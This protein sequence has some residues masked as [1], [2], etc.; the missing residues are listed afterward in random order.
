MYTLLDDYL[1]PRVTPERK[2]LLVQA[3]IT[4]ESLGH[5]AALDELNSVLMIQDTTDTVT[6]LGRIGTVVDTAQDQILLMQGIILSPELDLKNKHSILSLINNLEYYV[7]PDQAELLFMGD[8]DNESLLVNLVNMMEG[9]DDLDVMLSYVHQVSDQ[10]ISY[11]KDLVYSQLSARAVSNEYIAPVSKIRYINKVF[12]AFG[13]EPF[14]LAVDLIE[15]GTRIGNPLA[16]ILDIRLEQLGYEHEVLVPGLIG[17]VII[18]DVEPELTF[19]AVTDVIETLNLEPIEKR[20]HLDLMLEY[21]K[22]L[23]Q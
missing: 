9:V 18:S 1:E 21:K 16:G 20:L 7:Y 5:E 3:V 11:V 2:D 4:L 22:R 19:K 6:T 15:S 23:E 8:F 14:A 13:K 12:N 17:L 10:F